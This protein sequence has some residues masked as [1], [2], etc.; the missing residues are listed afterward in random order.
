MLISLVA[1]K[2]KSHL[3]LLVE[4]DGKGFDVDVEKDGI[5]TLNISSRISNLNGKLAYDSSPERGT[6]ATIR[7]PI[8]WGT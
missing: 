6:V 3:V 7:I 5:G 2:N 1:L 8:E 4:D